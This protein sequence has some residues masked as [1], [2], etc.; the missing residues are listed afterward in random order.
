MGDVFFSRRRPLSI[1]VMAFI[2]CTG[3]GG[4]EQVFAPK[5]EL[6][7]RWQAHNAANI[8]AIDH[9]AWSGLLQRYIKRGRDEIN[10]FKYGA[11]TAEDKQQLDRYI[12]S[13]TA[14]AISKHN[15]REQ[16]AYWINLY[17]ALT[18]KLILWR[19]PVQSILDIDISPG[20]LADGPWDKKLVDI[21][22]VAVSLNDIEHRILRPIWR[23]NRVHYA[24]NCASIGCPNLQ[25]Q[26]FTGGN[27]ESL[28][29]LGAQQ[30]INSARGV[31][32]KDEEV[33]ISKIYNWFQSDFGRT[34]Q[35]VL[36]HLSKYAKPKLKKQLQAIGEVS[37]FTYDWKLNEIK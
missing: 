16:L 6:W 34:E 28:L 10:Y 5:A 15:C 12:G 14:I 35:E 29:T 18:V 26:A 1:A 20:F 4:L 2:F 11:V 21:E 13:L 23:D 27:V 7:P 36:S 17:N 19:Y 9:R 8:T 33:T 37:D 22:G 31:A 32:V 25:N 30:Y 24:V 3:F